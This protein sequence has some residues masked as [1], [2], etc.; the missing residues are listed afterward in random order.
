MWDDLCRC[1]FFLWFEV[2]GRS[3]SNF[4]AP[5]VR[6]EGIVGRT[7]RG[8]L[9]VLVAFEIASLRSTSIPVDASLPEP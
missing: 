3:C 6:V 9:G 1:F 2:G 5:T 4:L 7:V 8:P